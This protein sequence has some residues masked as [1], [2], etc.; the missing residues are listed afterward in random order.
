MSNLPPEILAG[1]LSQSLAYVQ[2]I[3]Q[4][5]ASYIEQPDEEVFAETLRLMQVLQSG[6]QMLGL[7]S[8]SS[9]VTA[10]Q[11]DLEA[12][13]GQPRPY[14]EAVVSSL[15][16]ALD[17]LET[18]IRSALPIASLPAASIKPARKR[19]ADIP[20]DLMQIFAV[21]AS[22]HLESIH[23]SLET[24][25]KNAGDDEA[26]SEMRRVTHTLKGAAASVGFNAVA[27]VAHCMEE[28]SDQQIETGDRL[29]TEIIEL[30][31]DSADVL[32]LLTSADAGD[33]GD[34]LPALSMRYQVFLGSDSPALE[35]MVEDSADAPVGGIKMS[36]AQENTLRLPL[37]DI[38]T[39]INHV[40]E[41]IIT[42][43]LSE[44]HM[45]AFRT[46]ATELSYTARRLRRVARE[47][48]S[49]IESTA[50]RRSG[51]F[52][53]EFAA[54]D[55][56][57]LDRY[58]VLHQH[59]RELEEATS[60]AHDV[61]TKL[62]FLADD[63]DAVFRTERRLT[64]QLQEGL[65]STRLVAFHEVETRLRRIVQRT[66]TTV[67]KSVE[68]NVQGF[69]T[70]VDKTIL[71]ALIDPLTHLL[72]N[73]VDHGVESP[74]LRAR[75]GKT[76]TGQIT[77]SVRRDRGRVVVTLTDDG[78]GINP[79]EVR[80][81]AIRQRRLAED[82][83]RTTN[84]IVDLIFSEGFSLAEAVTETSGRGLGLNIVRRAVS[85]LQGTVHIDTGVGKGTTFTISV[86]VTLAITQ[87]LFVISS[88]QLLAIPMEQISAVLHLEADALQRI[89]QEKVL[90]HDGKVL[91][92]YDLG[93]FVSATSDIGQRRYA[94][95]VEAG[96]QS[97][98][99]L[100]DALSGT[101]EAVVK[102]LGSHLRRVYGISG[103]TIAGDG[104]VILIV[105]LV[106]LTTTQSAVR[107]PMSSAVMPLLS[108][109]E[110]GHVMVV[111][112][113]LSVRRV[114]STFLE[115][116][117]W[118]TTQAK[119]GI[120]ALERLA[121]VRPDVLLVDIE[122]PRMNGYELL[123]RVRED[124]RLSHLPVIFLT[125]RSATKHRERAQ[126]L[127]VDG[128]LVKPYHEDQ[129]LAEL[130]RVVNRELDHA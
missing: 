129:L 66:A 124:S 120:D 1:L 80:R 107:A 58:T 118:Q 50:K 10:L 15:N 95:L 40:G 20:D 55:A 49:Q 70:E 101:G 122:M 30:L 84:E 86:P 104:R 102:S 39:L 79:D 11:T 68:L 82:E 61:A 71:N 85:Q 8:I 53:P 75:R 47:I 114:V 88:G 67:G 41:I 81:A 48:D 32:E 18:E 12:L 83:T 28:L 90:H 14:D 110:G 112:D 117:G 22:E 92:V 116:S 99:V 109:A 5:L 7:A 63:F 106:E 97:A 26:I 24:L 74:E 31:L 108:Q 98:A 37:A 77:L 78:Q 38:D 111:D 21:E 52:S 45:S 96:P 25:R 19:S 29:S 127:G 3:R 62:S 60:D 2:S 17:A 113:S 105:D 4:G 64:G 51:S 16:S 9:M 59:T 27:R 115:R 125:S 126:Q 119:D 33:S 72:R 36:P 128:Y 13:P 35:M 42:R 23:R 44:E 57:E 43:S 103:A 56:L 87:A 100:I 73:A 91:S 121:T 123:T 89:Q 93:A 94:L 76:P 69:E 65:L 6:N 54:F 130:R 34:A 46:L